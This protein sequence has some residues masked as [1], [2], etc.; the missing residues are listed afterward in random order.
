[1]GG[2]GGAVLPRV[3]AKTI[4]WMDTAES[5]GMLGDRNM[6]RVSPGLG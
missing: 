1:M 5:P 2:G 3:S 4:W 6:S